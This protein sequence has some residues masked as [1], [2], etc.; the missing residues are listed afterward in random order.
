MQQHGCMT[1]VQNVQQV[2]RYARLEPSNR[3]VGVGHCTG[4]SFATRDVWERICRRSSLGR[5]RKRKGLE[6]ELDP[7]CF[8]ESR[9]D[10]ERAK[11]LSSGLGPRDIATEAACGRRLIDDARDDTNNGGAALVAKEKFES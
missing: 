9:R 3:S 4:F 5:D 7:R 1:E 11:D 2:S 8:V 10:T 6:S